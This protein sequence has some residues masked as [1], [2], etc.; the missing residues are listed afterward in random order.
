[1]MRSI[2]DINIELRNKYQVYRI[3]EY[4]DKYNR[5]LTK[6][7]GVLVAILLSPLYL[8]LGLFY[9]A[10][11]AW[12]KVDDIILYLGDSI[13]GV[14]GLLNTLAALGVF[15]ILSKSMIKKS[16]RERNE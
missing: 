15:K 2:N 11:W 12:D 14:I 1:M 16:E 5:T 8:L 10:T 9:V 3:I 13:E 7:L 6:A 4:L